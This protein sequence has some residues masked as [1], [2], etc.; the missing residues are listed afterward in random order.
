MALTRTQSTLIGLACAVC[1]MLFVGW[2]AFKI[3]RNP[4]YQSAQ[5]KP[6]RG[7]SHG[8]LITVTEVKINIETK[9]DALIFIVIDLGDGEKYGANFSVP[10]Y[11]IA[12]EVQAR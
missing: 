7:P 4:E 3:D 2:M 8:T 6:I 10:V 9:E 5:G 11:P 1:V 12:K